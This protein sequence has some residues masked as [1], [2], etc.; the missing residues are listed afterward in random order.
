MPVTLAL[1]LHCPFFTPNF[2]CMSTTIAFTPDPII[3]WLRHDPEMQ[4]RDAFTDTR[5]V[6]LNI[7]FE[8]MGSCFPGGVQLLTKRI[9]SPADLIVGAVYILDQQNVPGYEGHHWYNQC[10]MGRLEKAHCIKLG[11]FPSVDVLFSFDNPEAGAKA[12]GA[13][14]CDGLHHED[15]HFKEPRISKSQLG[16]AGEDWA[17]RKQKHRCQ[18]WQVTHY[19]ASP[20]SDDIADTQYAAGTGLNVGQ[21]Q[22]LDEEAQI[23]FGKDVMVTARSKG[24]DYAP[25]L[26]QQLDGERAGLIDSLLSEI[27]V[28][29][30]GRAHRSKDAIVALTRRNCERTI[31]EFY[32]QEAVHTVLDLLDGMHREQAAMTALRSRVAEKQPKQQTIIQAPSQAVD[33]KVPEVRKE[34]ALIA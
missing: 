27:S 13:R 5:A 25:T 22:W 32:S 31:T 9:H 4:T 15:I 14:I 30:A 2:S 20:A 6:T 33:N 21:R 26:E 3:S 23:Q 10:V 19:I 1:P 8:V 16:F 17:K 34:S 7:D 29:P 12:H 24:L 11:Q 28:I 18:L